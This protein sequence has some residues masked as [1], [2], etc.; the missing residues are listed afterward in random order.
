MDDLNLA[1]GRGLPSE[2]K[3]T[4]RVQRILRLFQGMVAFIVILGLIHFSGIYQYLFY[5]RTPENVS[6][7]NLESVLD[8]EAISLP[9]TVFILRNDGNF[10][11]R[12]SEEDVRR[13]VFN[14]SRIW[15]QANIELRV[16]KLAVLETSDKDLDVFLKTPGPFI[17]GFDGYD[18]KTINVF[19]VRTLGGVNGISFGGLRAVAIADYT[20]VY[21]FRA[22]AHEVG[23]VLGLDHTED[24][25]LLMYQGANGFKL[26]LGE[27]IRAR[28]AATDF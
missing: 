20:S 4:T 10:G 21:D 25:S 8:A 26:S 19:L 1:G 15:H 18:N 16:G 17:R 13:M 5:Q 22:L 3:E 27:I 11:S 14:A 9:L 12:R 24:T 2:P 7:G 28:E 6:E 23:H